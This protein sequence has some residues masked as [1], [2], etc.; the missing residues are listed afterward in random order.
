M[1]LSNHLSSSEMS[2]IWILRWRGLQT[3]LAANVF[4]YI[5]S[6]SLWG[7][8]LKYVHRTLLTYN[9]IICDYTHSTVKFVTTAGKTFNELQS[10]CYA[11]LASVPRKRNLPLRC[12]REVV[13]TRITFVSS[14]R[15]RYRLKLALYLVGSL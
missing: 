11:R 13:R 15:H 1:A 10:G 14:G 2:W 3:T 9:S 7:E 5:I 8:Y 4:S 12:S 6:Q